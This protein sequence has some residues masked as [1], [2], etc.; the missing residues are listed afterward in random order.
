[1][2]NPMNRRPL[3]RVPF[4]ALGLTDSADLQKWAARALFCSEIQTGSLRL[5]AHQ[6]QIRPVVRSVVWRLTRAEREELIRTA[7]EADQAAAEERL[8]VCT[9]LTEDA[10]HWLDLQVWT[11]AR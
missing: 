11:V 2:R 9:E 10:P 4:D 5:T 3:A 6:L 1:M 8:A 7:A